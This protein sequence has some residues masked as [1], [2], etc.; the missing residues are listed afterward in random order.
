[1]LRRPVDVKMVRTN[2]SVALY[3]IAVDV[4]EPA[5]LKRANRWSRKAIEAMFRTAP[6]TD[7]W[8]TIGGC[9]GLQHSGRKAFPPTHGGWRRPRVLDRRFRKSTRSYRD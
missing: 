3:Q 9:D 5:L 4:G 8:P 1:M 6:D 2:I 7:S